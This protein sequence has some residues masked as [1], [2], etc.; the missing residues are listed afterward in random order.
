MTGTDC[1]Q[2]DIHAAY[3]ALLQ[4]VYQ[5]PIGLVQCDGDGAITMINSM[6]AQLL[7]PLAPGGDLSNLFDALASVAPRLR[8][9]VRSHDASV[10]VICD[11]L[12]LPL[13]VAEGSGG[14]GPRTLSLQVV[15]IDAAKLMVSLTDATVAA[16]REQ[17]KVAARVRDATRIDSLTS[18]PN[19][20]VAL[21]CIGNALENA[22]VDPHYQFAVVFINIDRFSRINVTLGASAGDDLLRLMAGRLSGAVRLR[23]GARQSKLQVQTAARLGADEFVVVLEGLRQLQDVHVV[24]QRLVDAMSKPY[25]LAQQQVH[26]SVSVGVV[27]RAQAAGDADAVLQDARLA[28]REAKHA[29]GTRYC[30][31]EP[32]VRERAWRRGSLEGELRKALEADELFVQYQPIVDLGSGDVTGVE[33]LVRWRH[34]VRGTVPPGEFIDIAEETGLIGVLG[35]FVL[36]TA[37]RC[38]VDLQNRLGERA[39]QVLSV[40]LSR[41]QLAEPGLVEMVQQA[42]SQSGLAAEQLQLEVTES[43]AAQ[44]AQVQRRLHELKALGLTLALD[45]FGTGYSSLASLHLMPVDVVKIDRS[46]VNQAETS[47]HHRVLI[48]ATVRVARSLGMRTVAEGVETEGQSALLAGLQCDKGQGYLYA[49]PLEADALADWLLAYRRRAYAADAPAVVTTTGK[50]L[51]C[52]ER[53]NVG[54]ALFDPRERLAYANPSFREAYFEG[55]DG[56]PTWE[57]MLRHSHQH[58]SGVLIDTDDIDGWLASVRRRYRQVPRRTFESD[59]A[60][61]RWMRVNEETRPDGWQLTVAADVTSLKTSEAELRRAHEIALVASITDPLTGLPNRRFVFDRLAELMAEAAELRIALT[62]VA[63]DLDEFKAVNDVFGHAVGDRV[64]VWFAQRLAA[65]VRQRDAV[66]RIG[67]EEFLLVLANTGRQGAERVLRELRSVLFNE[68]LPLQSSGLAVRFSA[69]IAEAQAGDTPE[70]VCQ[71]ADQGLYRAK[72]AG[73]AQDCFVPGPPD[74]VRPALRRG[75]AAR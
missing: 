29:G 33:A 46:F 14:A 60:D 45:D 11:A 64:L 17:Q 57:E 18:L 50:L 34:P 40:N 62:V 28:M 41:A 66:G 24:A 42:L 19:R 16:R 72:A 4:F 36:R 37:C 43:L 31:F 2:E 35:E 26:A 23:D 13:P 51:E 20:A 68:P 27:V 61:G 10:A 67:G 39:P 25:G 75:R 63:I 1:M 49:R 47:M 15:R 58:R 56:L 74:P 12:L 71:R 44:N 48:E 54:I 30:I 9:T 3:E 55:R 21:E 8:E 22:R 59:M 5:A 7:M 69:G 52:L 38:I 6:A 65:L 32:H 53:S 70:V 73:R